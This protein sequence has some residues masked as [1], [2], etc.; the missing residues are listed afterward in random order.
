M[1]VTVATKLRK[2]RGY[3]ELSTSHLVGGPRQVTVDPPLPGQT[4]FFLRPYKPYHVQKCLPSSSSLQLGR[5]MCSTPIMAAKLVRSSSLLLL[6]LMAMWIS[7]CKLLSAAMA[8][9]TVQLA[10][11][12]AQPSLAA[13]GHAWPMEQLRLC[14]FAL[15]AHKLHY[16][17]VIIIGQPIFQ[18]T[19][20]SMPELNT[21]KWTITFS[22]KS[23][24]QTLGHHTH[25]YT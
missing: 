21:L 8:D 14:G 16:Y 12:L 15:I 22:C 11:S 7:S 1:Q 17:S 25:I 5:P 20:F 9:H 4:C 3:Q 6:L 18:L 23:S 24:Q 13:A 2:H 10:S 19:W